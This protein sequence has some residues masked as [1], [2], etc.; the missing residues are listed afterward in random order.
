VLVATRTTVALAQH[1]VT[2][3]SVDLLKTLATVERI[4]LSQQPDQANRLLAALDVYRGEFMAAF[5]LDDAPRFTAWIVATR[6]HI[7]QQMVAAYRKLGQ[8][9]LN[10]RRIKEGIAIAQQW[11]AVN[12]LDEA[13]HTLLIQ[14]YIKADNTGEAVA[15]YEHVVDLLWTEL[16]VQPSAALTAL[17]E[18]IRPK[19]VANTP[20]TA[21]DNLPAAYNQF[22]GRKEVREAIH[23]R[24]NQPF[25]RLISIVGQGGVGKTRLATTIAR[26]RRTHYPDGVWLIELAE[27]D[28]NDD[29]LAEAIAIEIANTLDMRLEGAA[30]PIEQLLNYLRYRRMLLILDN[31]DHLFD[32]VQIVLD[33]VRQC[34][35]VQLLATSREALRVRAEWVVDLAGL[36]YPISDSDVL[37]SDAVDLF[38]ARQAQHQWGE[39]SAE[40]LAAVRRICNMVEGLPLAIEIAAALTRQ[41]P[42]R[43]VAERLRAGFGILATSLHDIPPRHRS[44]R[45]V[46]EMS[47]QL[48]TPPSQAC[49]ARLSV[50][51]GSF[52]AHAAQ[53][54][55]D[56]AQLAVLQEKSLVAYD[57]NVDRYTLHPIVRAYAAE[58]RLP[59]DSTAQKYTHYYLTWLAQHTLRLQKD[60]PQLSVNVIMLDI[61]NVRAA[62][63]T[64]L[65]ARD[66]DLLFNA[67]TA[68]SAYYQ[69][70]GLAYEGEAVMRTTLAAASAWGADGIPLA[71]RAGLEQV[72]F[73]NRLGRSR[74]AIQTLKTVLQLADQ[75]ADRWAEGMGYVWWG[76]ALWRLGEYDSAESKL[77]HAFNVARTLDEPLILGWYHHQLGIIYDLRS[78]C[79]AAI[80]H[81]NR[82]SA[83]WQMLDNVSALAV[84]LN[85]IG[86]VR[87]HQGELAAAQE[88]WAQA[89]THCNQIGNRHLQTFLLNNLGIISIERQDYNGA[90]YYLQLSLNLATING[91]LAGQADNYVNLG[92]TH[93]LQGEL[94]MAIINLEK[95][96][97]IA[98][99]IGSRTTIAI[100]LLYLAEISAEQG[101]MA[102][103]EVNC[104]NA[105]ATARLAESKQIECEA[106]ID[107]AQVLGQRDNEQARQYGEEAVTLAKSLQN[108]A[109]LERAS[110]AIAAL[111]E[112]LEELTLQA[113]S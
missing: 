33:I 89:L 107:L 8:H 73:Q 36:A 26:H 66:A 106:L 4:N 43:T 69:L 105:L 98:Q 65:A 21:R 30:K 63:Q 22:F 97:Q 53:Q 54:V 77:T 51:Q 67:L 46:F 113:G 75:C 10:T 5:E 50:F 61:D 84:S 15:H 9:A 42:A 110:E 19:V 18:R 80:E 57:A 37:P 87:Y 17:V 101:D 71:T 11:L 111:A 20:T 72:R 38:L 103:A 68:L 27:L 91:N 45:I 96:L 78:R 85:S 93:R 28:P 76:E 29:D 12:E 90:H 58:K 35:K 99:S 86:L 102:Q 48:L 49:L 92:K 47:W 109:L 6:E 32:G 82:A 25:C 39:I 100:A 62:W 3:D 79:D 55:A 83:I 14:L 40:T 95:G 2:V 60:A 34:E 13:A 7:R 112:N 108:S 41:M 64:A 104:R 44:L 81:L 16:G 59:N 88:A 23:A 94:D 70:R 56:A 24:L 31:F 1:V 74:L 52:T